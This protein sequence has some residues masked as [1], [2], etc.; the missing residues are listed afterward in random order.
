V[1]RAVADF[2]LSR[3][4][5]QWLHIEKIEV[6]SKCQKIRATGS[7]FLRS[8][9]TIIIDQEELLKA[10]VCKT[11]GEEKQEYMVIADCEKV[12]ITNP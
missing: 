1:K 11:K 6:C 2:L 4:N 9:E 8:F 12:T 3:E 10:T 5:L 7:S